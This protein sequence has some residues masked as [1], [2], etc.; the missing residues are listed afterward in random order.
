MKSIILISILSLTSLNM[1][2]DCAYAVH[3]IC[4]AAD[5]D[6]TSKSINF[7]FVG[8]RPDDGRSC[9][10]Y[11]GTRTENV[12]RD[13]LENKYDIGS[14][15]KIDIL[16]PDMMSAIGPSSVSDATYLSNRLHQECMDN[17]DTEK[18]YNIS[19]EVELE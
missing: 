2:A 14:I 7:D 13:F 18:C 10:S 1:Y 6:E 17:S 16:D 12:A 19:G 3:A 15:C 11:S 8:T 5:F 4:D 9:A